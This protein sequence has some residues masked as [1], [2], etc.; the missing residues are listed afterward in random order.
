MLLPPGMCL[1]NTDSKGGGD[2]ED[3]CLF[4]ALFNNLSNE[5]N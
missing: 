3:Q 4:P 1:K 2:V 5:G